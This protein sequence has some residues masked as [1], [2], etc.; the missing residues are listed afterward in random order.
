M[1]QTKCRL[2]Y[3]GECPVCRLY[4]ESIEL[5]SSAANLMLVDARQDHEL[6][7]EV[8]K[9]QLDLDQ[10][11]VL[12][13]DG[14]LY[15]GAQALH[16]LAGFGRR[17]GV[18]NQINYWLFKSESRANRLYPLLRAL[19]NGLLKVRGKPKINNLEQPNND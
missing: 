14:S 9:A 15:Y 18:F 17:S 11:M 7:D 8:N 2:V 10:G 4:C 12:E 13:V 16:A 1:P 3:D 19:R 5:E 6:I